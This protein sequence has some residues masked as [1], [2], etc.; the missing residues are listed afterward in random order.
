VNR[1]GY[2]VRLSAISGIQSTLQIL[3]VVV[4]AIP[5]RGLIE[6]IFSRDV[7]VDTTATH[8]TFAQQPLTPRFR[9]EAL[10]V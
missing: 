1:L 3:F 9:L 2:Q 6:R 7:S 4:A 8:R 5:V 10:M